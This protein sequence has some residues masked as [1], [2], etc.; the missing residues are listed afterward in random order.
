MEA[1]SS[2]SDDD[3]GGIMRASEARGGVSISGRGLE[4]RSP[5]AMANH[6]YQQQAQY[7]APQ[8]PRRW[9][10][11]VAQKLE[12]WVFLYNVT[13]GLY[14]LEWWE[15]YLFNAVFVVLFALVGYN[16]GHYLQRM[17]AGLLAWA[18]WGDSGMEL[19][20][21]AGAGAGAPGG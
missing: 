1:A 16:S 2:S 13:T 5:T 17:G 19:A 14:M 6:R 20:G 15:R 21:G 9:H 18:W 3:H 12:R 7:Q 11:R 10:T 8:A 4:E